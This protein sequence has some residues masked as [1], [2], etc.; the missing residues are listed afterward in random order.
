MDILVIIKDMQR[1][2]LSIICDNQNFQR[3]LLKRPQEWDNLL[4]NIHHHIRNSD[5]EFGRM[6]CDVPDSSD[7]ERDE[8]INGEYDEVHELDRD[9]SKDLNHLDCI[10]G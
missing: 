8:G 6:D 1:H 5:A 7:S 9:D 10:V 4:T 3:K 2:L